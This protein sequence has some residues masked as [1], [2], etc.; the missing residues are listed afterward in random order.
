MGIALFYLFLF[1][2]AP[3]VLSVPF[4]VEFSFLFVEFPVFLRNIQFVC[5]FA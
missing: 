5:V 3:Y 1:C 2:E 4:F